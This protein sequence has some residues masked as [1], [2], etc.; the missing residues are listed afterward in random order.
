MLLAFSPEHLC[1][2]LSRQIK[3]LLSLNWQVLKVLIVKFQT[4]TLDQCH[5]FLINLSCKSA[6]IPLNAHYCTWARSHRLRHSD[7]AYSL[8]YLHASDVHQH[9]TFNRSQTATLL[10]G[11]VTSEGGLL[12][13]FSAYMKCIQLSSNFWAINSRLLLITVNARAF[14]HIWKICG[15]FIIHKIFW[16][17]S[18]CSIKLCSYF[19]LTSFK[20]FD[21]TAKFNW[22]HWNIRWN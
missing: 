22:L 3:S 15:I 21:E 4:S 16:P 8:L 10:W 7:C 14:Q 12:Q 13:N 17:C 9:S 18:T 20:L 19:K 6:S 5:H 2:D 11:T 1:S